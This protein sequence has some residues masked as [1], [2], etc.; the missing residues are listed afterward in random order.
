[1][2]DS[3][4][5]QSEEKEQIGKE[6]ELNDNQNK[7]SYE[8]L[9]N[10][11]KILEEFSQIGI[12]EFIVDPNTKQPRITY[13]ND[14]ITQTTGYSKEEFKK[15]SL[16]K[17]FTAE[18]LKKFTDIHKKVRSGEKVTDGTEYQIKTKSGNLH[19]IKFVTAWTLKDGKPF[20]ARVLISDATNIKETKEQLKIAE[21]RYRSIFDESPFGILIYELKDENLFLMTMNKASEKILRIKAKNFIGK[22]IE[23]C[24]PKL[25]ERGVSKKYKKIA[26]RG[27]ILTISQYSYEDEKNN[28]AGIYDIHVFQAEVNK[29]AIMFNDVTDKAIAEERSRRLISAMNDGIWSINK[30][31]E[32]TYA[33]PAFIE[34]MEYSAEEIIGKTVEELITKES[35]KIWKK[36]VKER[37]AKEKPTN[38]YE[39]TL[40]TKTG[41]EIIARVS[42]SVLLDPNERVLGSFAVITDI[43]I[44]K[45]ILATQEDMEKKRSEFMAL[46]SHELRTP[47][48]ILKGYLEIL[49]KKDHMPRKEQMKYLGIAKKNI[50]RLE[51]LIT[52]VS[53]LTKIQRG[54]FELKL[55]PVNLDSYLM[56]TVNTYSDLLGEGFSFKTIPVNASPTY[57]EIDKDRF[58]HV[59]NNVIRNSI[60]HSPRDSKK[61]EVTLNTTSLDIVQ[62]KITDSGAGIAK[63]NLPRIFEPYVSFTSKYNVKGTGIGLFLS[64]IIIDKHNGHIEISSKGV[65]KGTTVIISLP[66]IH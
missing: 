57:L 19:W 26:K 28:I 23:E 58:K 41:K 22:T 36:E 2:E 1:M 61:I 4:N 35:V 8:K 51:Y 17:L 27:G 12:Y 40:K 66:R 30:K 16:K 63:E 29:T 14:Y 48:T 53:E 59:L 42:A 25:G 32:T 9:L 49:A 31:Y 43:T 39:L 10:D 64:K 21:K 65:G 54:I 44:E 45:Q 20:S 52:D 15:L 5:I 46:T 55:D 7:I 3:S 56:E 11:Y 34:M 13:A 62:I 50:N 33:N 6:D 38:T 47:L 60:N 18:S 37:F 24:F